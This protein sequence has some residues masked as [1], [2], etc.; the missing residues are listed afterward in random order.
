MNEKAVVQTIVARRRG[1]ACHIV[2]VREVISPSGQGPTFRFV[3]AC[4]KHFEMPVTMDSMRR[5]PDYFYSQNG[6]LGNV[7][8]RRCKRSRAAQ[9]AG[10][11]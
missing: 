9:K 3:T 8:C 4:R 10:G 7:D 2:I 5:G 11:E 1:S 6:V